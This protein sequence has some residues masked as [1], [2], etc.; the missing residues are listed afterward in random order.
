[1]VK[2]L[3]F[4]EETYYIGRNGMGKQKGIGFTRN[5]NTIQLEPINSKGHLSNCAINVP[6]DSIP[7]MIE[8]LNGVL[9]YEASFKIK[10]IKAIIDEWGETTSSEL[11][12]NASPCIQ[13]FGNGK[14]NQSQLIEGY[15]RDGVV[16]DFYAGEQ[17]IS[18]HEL[19]YEK[20]SFDIICQVA[21]IM[22]KYY[23]DCYAETME[24]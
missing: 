23:S 15:Q 21:E 8:R 14:L 16:I 19:P 13:S 7:A 12:L 22:E 20:L 18:S 11:K 17:H 4:T 3:I 2:D 24:E 6:I 1:M 9:E 10:R 5:M